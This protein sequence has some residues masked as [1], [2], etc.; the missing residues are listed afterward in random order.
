MERAAKYEGSCPSDCL[1][2][3]PSDSVDLCDIYHIEQAYARFCTILIQ[4]Y[5]AVFWEKERTGMVG[6]AAPEK[7]TE[8]TSKSSEPGAATFTPIAEE[9][10]VMR[11]GSLIRSLLVNIR[12]LMLCVSPACVLAQVGCN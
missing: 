6:D 10:S 9:L 7:K 1:W 4:D 3:L 5:L 8:D 12:C 11:Y 2:D